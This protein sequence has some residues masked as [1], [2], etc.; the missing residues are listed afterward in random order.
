MPLVNGDLAQT[1]KEP[2]E[3]VTLEEY[4]RKEVDDFGQQIMNLAK[5]KSIPTIFGEKVVMRLLDIILAGNG[6]IE[7]N[8]LIL[9][10]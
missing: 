9:K 1:A 2:V 8:W 10:Q 5:E 6:T 4:Y 7:I 3:V